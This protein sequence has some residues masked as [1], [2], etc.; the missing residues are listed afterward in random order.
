[1]W[2]RW[3]L[4]MSW[5]T[6]N[7]AE[8]C[9][10]IFLAHT[11]PSISH[12]TSFIFHFT[13]PSIL[14]LASFIFHLK[15]KYFSQDFFHI[16]LKAEIFYHSLPAFC[17]DQNLSYSSFVIMPAA[18]INSGFWWLRD[19]GSWRGNSDDHDHDDDHNDNDD[20]DHNRDEDNDDDHLHSG[21]RDEAKGLHPGLIENHNRI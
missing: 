17:L 8:D 1:M 19:E 4:K 18:W 15:P 3:C 9:F 21:G 2:R 20:H 11:T 14:S 6:F 5:D 13:S 16:S 10:A 12:K 7:E